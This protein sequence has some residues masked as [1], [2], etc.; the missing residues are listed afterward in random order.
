MAHDGATTTTSRTI[1]ETKGDLTP[2]LKAELPKL[3]EDKAE[4]VRHVQ[5]RK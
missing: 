5:N 3:S 4:R 1:G 2:E